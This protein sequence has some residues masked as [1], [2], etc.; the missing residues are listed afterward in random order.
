ALVGARQTLDGI[1]QIRALWPEH[2]LELV[3]VVPT[4]VNM[5]T[6][7]TR[8]TLEAIE[9]DPRLRDALFA[10][11]IRQCI[12]LTYASA[13]GQSIWDYAPHSRGA[14]DY[15]ALLERIAPREATALPAYG[16]IEKAET[17]VQRT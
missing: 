3:A 17:I 15:T 8:A 2:T 10:N 4:A 5:N 9:Q 11:G 13:S 6:H 16:E 1:E 14:A 12:D 7:A